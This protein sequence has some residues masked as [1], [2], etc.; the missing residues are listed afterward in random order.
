MLSTTKTGRKERKGFTL[1]ELLVVIAIIAILAAILFPVFARARAKAQQTVCLSNVKQLTL[2]FMMYVTDWQKFPLHFPCWAGSW[3]PTH[4]PGSPEGWSDPFGYIW[5][6]DLKHWPWK[7]MPYI[8]NEEIFRCPSQPDY[9][10]DVWWLDL[11]A[12]WFSYTTNNIYTNHSDQGGIALDAVPNPADIVLLSEWNVAAKVCLWPSP[13]CAYTQPGE[14]KVYGWAHVAAW[15]RQGLKVPHHRG[16]NFGFGDGHAKWARDG[17]LGPADFGL[18]GDLPW[19]P[20]NEW[21]EG[22]F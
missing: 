2:G 16:A 14:P 5:P 22:L 18:A 20:I 21:R 15:E 10:H 4:P 19:D 17:T 8:R 11:D 6:E 3:W 9:P 12:P 13:L 1:I 7:I